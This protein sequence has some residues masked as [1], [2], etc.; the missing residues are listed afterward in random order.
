MSKATHEQGVNVNILLFAVGAARK[1][2]CRYGKINVAAYVGQ[3]TL[4]PYIQHEPQHT[5][6]SVILYTVLLI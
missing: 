5:T 3:L 4:F 1:I 6:P 2:C